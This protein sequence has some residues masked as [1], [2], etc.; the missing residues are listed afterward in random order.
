MDPLGIEKAS[1][2]KERITSA[3]ATAQAIASTYSRS[4]VLRNRPKWASRA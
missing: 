3:R 2:M 1:K 4:I